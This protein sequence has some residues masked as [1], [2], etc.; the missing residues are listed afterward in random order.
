MLYEDFH[1]TS[2]QILHK[3]AIYSN[4]ILKRRKDNILMSYETVIIG[5]ELIKLFKLGVSELESNY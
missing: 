3:I 4:F 1:S 2:K 5:F